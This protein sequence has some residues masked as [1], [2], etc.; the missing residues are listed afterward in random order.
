MFHN[1]KCSL[2]KSTKVS[3]SKHTKTVSTDNAGKKTLQSKIYIL[4]YRI[5]NSDA[6]CVRIIL[7]LQLAKVELIQIVIY[8]QL[9]A[10]YDNTSQFLCYLFIFSFMIWICK[11]M[12][13]ITFSSESYNYLKAVLRP[14]CGE[15][16]TNL[17]LQAKMFLSKL[18]TVNF[19]GHLFSSIV[20]G[21]DSKERWFI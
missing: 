5:I 4:Y 2:S 3:P 8:G 7:M 14:R 15:L 16:H 12:Q 21:T 9:T 10:L 20:L 13:C 6:L 17:F 19:V 11:V 1:K 18:E